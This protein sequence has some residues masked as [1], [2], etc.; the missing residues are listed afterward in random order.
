[1]K[2]A[3]QEG[4]GLGRP[5]RQATGAVA[6]GVERITE[7]RQ[8]RRQL[9]AQHRGD[10]KVCALYSSKR[11][12]KRDVIFQAAWHFQWASTSPWL[13]PEPVSTLHPCSGGAGPDLPACV[14]F[15]GFPSHHL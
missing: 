15:S 10:A 3:A 2:A 6:C 9:S 14:S 11:E 1:M 8:P 7:G 4:G 12:D 5:P 13:P